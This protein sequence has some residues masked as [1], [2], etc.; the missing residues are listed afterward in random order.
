MY[1]RAAVSYFNGH[2]NPL[3]QGKPMSADQ[4]KCVANRVQMRRV[5]ESIG[6]DS[7]EGRHLT[8]QY[9]CYVDDAQ[10]IHVV[11]SLEFDR[12][13]CSISREN[14]YHATD[15]EGFT[16]L[17]KRVADDC[18]SDGALDGGFHDHVQRLEGCW[19]SFVN[20]DARGLSR[21]F[22]KNAVWYSNGE[23]TPDEWQSRAFWEDYFKAVEVNSAQVVLAA[24]NFQE[25]RVS[26]L[27]EWEYTVRDDD[28]TND[29]EDTFTA[30]SAQNAEFNE[31]GDVVSLMQV[32][33]NTQP[34]QA[35]LGMYQVPVPDVLTGFESAA[36]A[37]AYADGNRQFGRASYVIEGDSVEWARP[38][39]V[40]GLYYAKLWDGP[41]VDVSAAHATHLQ[42]FARVKISSQRQA[43]AESIRVDVQY[44]RVR[45]ELSARGE[46][47]AEAIATLYHALLAANGGDA[48]ALR[49]TLDSTIQQ[50]YQFRNGEIIRDADGAPDYKDYFNT[51]QNQLRELF[52]L[53]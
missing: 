6:R 53:F 3:T 17:V 25:N 46:T 31:D 39:P 21:C 35:A 16:R 7:D 1:H 23:L 9:A 37:L 27:V 10:P 13:T 43:L 24:R 8:L 48:V 22:A 11:H 41:G 42:V 4:A 14:V 26:A 18:F 28:D 44:D 49:S 5:L 15:G 51:L 36:A 33:S 29:A 34:I 47:V 2:L 50:C 52:Q 40:F 32:E 45:R 12:A 38:D 20:E 30:Y 19:A